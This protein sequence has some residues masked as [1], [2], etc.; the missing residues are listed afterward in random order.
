MLRAE[1]VMDVTCGLA[2]NGK[3]TWAKIGEIP[4]MHRMSD[5]QWLV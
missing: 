2:A 1:K 4:D 3:S 5:I